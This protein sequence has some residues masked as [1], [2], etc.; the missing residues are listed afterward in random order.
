MLTPK[1]ECE[2]PTRLQLGCAFPSVFPAVLL[3]GYDFGRN[4][5]QMWKKEHLSLPFLGTKSHH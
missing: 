1:I 5:D 2:K 3:V 4:L